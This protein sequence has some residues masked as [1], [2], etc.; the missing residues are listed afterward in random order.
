MAS[1]C[2]LTRQTPELYLQ[3]SLLERN[4]FTDEARQLK[5]KGWI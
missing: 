2:L 4:A 3:L 1:W 5:E